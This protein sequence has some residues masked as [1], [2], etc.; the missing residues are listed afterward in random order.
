M[1][2]RRASW[3]KA[4]PTIH[5]RR[6][7]MRIFAIISVAA[8]ASCAG[9]ASSP[10]STIPIVPNLR[11]FTV[12]NAVTNGIYVGQFN[13]T[14][15]FGYQGENKRNAPPIC[16]ENSGDAV[17]DIATDPKGNLIVPSQNNEQIQVYKGPAMCGP[18]VT[19]V[20]DPYGLPVDAASAN[21]LTGKIAVANILDDGPISNP[22]P[23]SITLCTMAHGCATNLTNP[24]MNE[25]AGVALDKG[26]DCWA[27]AINSSNSATLTFFA[28]CRGK[29]R[30]ARAYKNS[31]YGGL[32]VDKRGDILALDYKAK[33]LFVYSGC[34]PACKLLG[35]P[36]TLQGSSIYGKLNRAGTMFAAADYEY[37]QVDIY[38]YD[39][40][41]LTYE[42]SFNQDLSPSSNP[43]GIA[44]TPA[45]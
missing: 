27:S 40:T 36:F 33:Q 42:F 12:P 17:A 4:P 41:S 28:E 2:S 38:K 24:N 30:A 39:V 45:L 32:E 6:S 9:V 22:P 19:A 11:K 20:H 18:S 43:E 10:S 7:N 21:A 44:Y 1:G 35:G 29:G 37:G 3:L 26:G 34:N 13:G 23:G 14:A 16:G 31:S 5:A 25:V 15:V 8:L